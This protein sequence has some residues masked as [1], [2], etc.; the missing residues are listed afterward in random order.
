MVPKKSRKTPQGLEQ[1]LMVNYFAKFLLVN[2][3]KARE[4][5]KIF[6]LFKLTFTIFFRSPKKACEPVVYLAASGD[7]EGKTIDYLFLMSRKEMDEKA[8]DPENARMLWEKSES[9]KT[10]M[11]DTSCTE[12]L[13]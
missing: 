13:A 11:L 10:K 6:P 1:M 5:P 2:S 8:A 3:N 7:V 4:V 12:A 9:L